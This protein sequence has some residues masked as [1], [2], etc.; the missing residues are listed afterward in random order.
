MSDFS[1]A[2]WIDIRLSLHQQCSLNFEGVRSGQKHLGIGN[3][4]GVHF[5][6][7]SCSNWV[8]KLPCMAI[9]L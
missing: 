1:E 5:E 3:M 7:K 9:S 6:D 8:W 2:R 4:F